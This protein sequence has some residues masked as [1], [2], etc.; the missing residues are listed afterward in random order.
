MTVKIINFVPARDY[1]NV[2]GFIEEQ[3]HHQGLAEQV[4]TV[5]HLATTT[6]NAPSP[7]TPGPRSGSS[8]WSGRWSA[9]S[10]AS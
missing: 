2:R 10:A 7:P 1:D 6:T 5:T 4:N 3:G 9:S 8:A